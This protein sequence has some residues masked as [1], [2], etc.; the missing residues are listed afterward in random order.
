MDNSHKALKMREKL[1]L[2]F[3]LNLTETTHSNEQTPSPRINPTEM[4]INYDFKF[5]GILLK[6]KSSDA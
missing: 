1:L 3:K 2:H 5:V 6:T 4:K